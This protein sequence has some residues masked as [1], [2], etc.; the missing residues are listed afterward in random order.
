MLGGLLKTR[1]DMAICLTG[2]GWCRLFCSLPHFPITSTVSCFLY[3]LLPGPPGLI[4]CW[5]HARDFPFFWAFSGTVACPST[6]FSFDFLHIGSCSCPRLPSPSFT[7][8]LLD[9]TVPTASSASYHALLQMLRFLFSLPAGNRSHGFSVHAYVSV[10]CFVCVSL[11]ACIFPRKER[12]ASKGTGQ[13]VVPFTG[14]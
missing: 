13:G 11:V 14:S 1:Q 12:N 8:C 10:P 9:C 7:L 5:Y 2:T 6:L 3:V 4:T